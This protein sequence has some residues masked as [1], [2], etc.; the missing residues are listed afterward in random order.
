MSKLQKPDYIIFIGATLYNDFVRREQIERVYQFV[1]DATHVD[2]FPT[3]TKETI[4][5]VFNILKFKKLPAAMFVMDI[6]FDK[7]C[8]QLEEGYGLLP[9]EKGNGKF[10][11]VNGTLLSVKKIYPFKRLPE[12]ARILNRNISNFKLFGDEDTLL[13]IEKKLKD[14]VSIIKLL[15]TWYNLKVE[16]SKGE[17]ALAKSEDKLKIKLLPVRSL[18]AAIVEYFTAKEKT[19]T[20][21]ESC[22]GGL[23]A[24]KLTSVSGASNII[25]GTIVA[26]SNDIKKEWLG[27]KGETLQNFGA[28]SKECVS[29]ML[30]GAQERAKADIALAIS[31]IAGPTGGTD[32]KPVGTVFIGVKN[33]D[34]K[35]I[36]EYH[37]EGDRAFVQE[38]S[39]RAALKMLIFSEE[40]FFDFFKKN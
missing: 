33:G 34:K 37:F 29:E 16:K 40:G 8:K 21:A 9:I 22:T 1:N 13:N 15:P 7:V 19:I 24:A 31:G 38:Q 36:K 14:N 11:S 2:R 26:Y 23:L 35:E 17:C 20:C 25:K 12:P 3:Y 18:R 6:Y 30:D 5:D 10:Y 32:D 4:D 39:A 28:V 27:V